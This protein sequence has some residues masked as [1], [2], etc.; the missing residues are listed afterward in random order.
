MKTLF[1]MFTGATDLSNCSLELCQH[2]NDYAHSAKLGIARFHNDV[3]RAIQSL[4]NNYNGID[5][6]STCNLDVLSGNYEFKPSLRSEG[7]VEL[8]ENIDFHCDGDLGKN[9]TLLNGKLGDAKNAV[10]EAIIHPENTANMQMIEELEE[11]FKASGAKVDFKKTFDQI[12]NA[13]ADAGINVSNAIIRPKN[14]A[15]ISLLKLH[16]H[17]TLATLVAGV[18][19][20]YSSK[21]HCSTNEML[22]FRRGRGF[23]EVLGE[24][25]N[26]IKSECREGHISIRTWEQDN[27]MRI[28]AA[29]SIV[30]ASA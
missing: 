12:R 2:V 9:V 19:D 4:F 29:R 10:N 6:A 5:A 3:Q 14:L 24:V 15:S 27:D 22:G 28:L 26:L 17:P 20:Y 21:H 11:C 8:P 25:D 23:Y 1:A 30:L 13:A 18:F 7:Y 16:N